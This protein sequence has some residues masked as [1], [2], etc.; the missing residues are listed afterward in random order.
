M[1]ADGVN[2]VGD[3]ITYTISV[4]NSGTV[5]LSSYSISDTLTDGNSTTLSLTGTVSFVHT[6]KEALFDL[7]SY[8]DFW[9]N[10]EPNYSGESV[11]VIHTNTPFQVW[12]DYYYN[13]RNYGSLVERDDGATSLSGYNYIAS[14]EGHSYFRRVNY[15]YRWRD[16]QQ[17]AFNQGAYLV[18]ID[19]PA[20]Y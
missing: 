7:S 11:A 13:G 15:D 16:A 8:S 20:E 3:I 19:S 1:D 17:T 2:S 4:T 18:I 6:R 12:D 10:N 5:K 14:F 9:Q